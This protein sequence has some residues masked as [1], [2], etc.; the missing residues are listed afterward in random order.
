MESRSI[1][2]I[3]PHSFPMARFRKVCS[4]STCETDRRRSFL[5]RRSAFIREPMLK[6]IGRSMHH[7]STTDDESSCDAETNVLGMS[8]QSLSIRARRKKSNSVSIYPRLSIDVSSLVDEC[9]NLSLRESDLVDRAHCTHKLETQPSTS[10][11]VNGSD[12]LNR[13]ICAT[14]TVNCVA[15]SSS[16]SC[17]QQARIPSASCDVT[18]DELASYFETFVHIPKKMSTMAEMMYI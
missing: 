7:Y 3:I 2:F 13:S 12:Q 5:G 1:S 14:T 4:I 15:A 9:V 8:R 16:S 17:S 11:K 18:M 6:R 10:M